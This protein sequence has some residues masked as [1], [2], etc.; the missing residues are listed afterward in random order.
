MKDIS[1]VKISIGDIIVYAS[2][3]VGC[4][5]TLKYA[6]VV[7]T[8]LPKKHTGKIEIVGETSSKNDIRIYAAN[9]LMVIPRAVA[10][11]KVVNNL[12]N[13]WRLR[14]NRHSS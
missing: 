10:P 11:S 7:K 9:R 12:I 4:G 6:M 5:P 13:S 8:K 1:G 14:E 2:D 3:N